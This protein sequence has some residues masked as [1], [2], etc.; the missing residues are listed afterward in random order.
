MPRNYLKK[1][2]TYWSNRALED[3]IAEKTQLGTSFEKLSKKNKIPFDTLHRHISKQKAGIPHML[4]KRGKK[5]SFTSNE[6]ADLKEC[7]VSLA[8]LGFAPSIR[9]LGALVQ[10]Y[11]AENNAEKALKV[12]NYK[13]SK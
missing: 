5:S 10:N 11:V 1:E 4:E 7:V 8:S 6:K 3:A 2:K 12:L 13:G 9:D